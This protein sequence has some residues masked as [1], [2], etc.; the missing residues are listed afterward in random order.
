MPS[1]RALTN[2][3]QA[4][5]ALSRQDHEKAM[6]HLH[7]ARQLWS[8]IDGRV[9]IVRLRL[10][11]CRL[12]LEHGDIRG[13]MAEVHAAQLVARELGS[14]KL[15]GDCMALQREIDGWQPATAPAVR[16]QGIGR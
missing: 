1:I 12:Q 4:I 14:P 9:Q 15:S 11:I 2:E 7:L 10:Q 8:S 6:R 13:T 16:R 3:A 5:L